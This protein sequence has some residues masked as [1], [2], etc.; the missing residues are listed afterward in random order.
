MGGGGEWFTT[1][2]I[3]CTSMYTLQCCTILSWEKE[4][5]LLFYPEYG[6]EG[7]F[8]TLSANITCHCK[9]GSLSLCLPLF[10]R[11]SPHPGSFAEILCCKDHETWDS[12]KI[13]YGFFFINRITGQKFWRVVKDRT[14]PF[15][16]IGSPHEYRCFFKGLY[17]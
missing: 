5:I 8:S 9:R 11:P 15:L 13:L 17:N 12:N 16:E 3:I 2:Q 6:G 1:K 7:H 10:L 14:G 4:S